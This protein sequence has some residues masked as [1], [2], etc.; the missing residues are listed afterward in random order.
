[1]QEITITPEYNPEMSPRA[2]AAFF[3]GMKP[4]KVN[5]RQ[6]FYGVQA[7]ANGLMLGGGLCDGII[8][9]IG[10]GSLNLARQLYA[11]R[12]S[13]INKV[14]ARTHKKVRPKQRQNI[15]HIKK[16]KKHEK[17]ANFLGVITNS[18]QATSFFYSNDTL[19]Q[20]MPGMAMTTGYGLMTTSIHYDEAASLAE[21]DFLGFHLAWHD[22]TADDQKILFQNYGDE[23]FST[24]EEA[25]TKQRRAQEKEA[26]FEMNAVALFS[27]R[28]FMQFTVAVQDGLTETYSIGEALTTLAGAT[29]L[30]ASGHTI[31]KHLKLFTQMIH[32]TLLSVEESGNPFSKNQDDV[33]TSYSIKVDD[34]PQGIL[35]RRDDYK[36]GFE[37]MASSL[38]V[39][40][41][42][43]HNI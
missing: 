10:T 15:D 38:R 7:L 39:S 26:L 29:F 12:N 21:R 1:M 35:K 17:F 4:K 19:F 37:K 28:A 20:S 24:A 31:A 18:V 32:R 9:Y 6:L 23:V 2:R 30:F 8:G 14:R 25:L 34:I 36:D 43:S 16:S 13:D 3:E 42:Q 22:L 11:W 40:A 33:C 5:G 41:A 27:L